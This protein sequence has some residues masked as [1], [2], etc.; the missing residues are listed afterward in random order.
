MNDRFDSRGRI[1][2]PGEIR[3]MWQRYLSQWTMDYLTCRATRH[4]RPRGSQGS[5][6]RHVGVW[7]QMMIS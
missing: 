7:P 1:E 3:R 2:V 6:H 5:G 4:S